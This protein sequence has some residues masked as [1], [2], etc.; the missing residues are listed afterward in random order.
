MRAVSWLF[1]IC[2][3]L[4]TIGVF[5][6]HLEVDIKSKHNSLSLYRAQADRKLA[7]RLL[8]GYGKSKSKK[9][10]GALLGFLMPRSKGT[11]HEVIDDT[12]SAMSELDDVSVDDAKSAG[13]MLAA[14]VWTYFGLQMAGFLLVLVGVVNDSYRR[15]RLI[16][17]AVTSL[18]TAAIAIACH[19]GAREIAAEANDEIGVHVFD[20][21][22]GSYLMVG[23]GIAAF[24]L[25]L[26]LVGIHVRGTGWKRYPLKASA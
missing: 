4:G 18:V 26:A 13:L 8:A 23:A 17:A 6:S 21:G 2:T 7:A 22:L 9:V 14:V 24:L 5:A 16:V 25:A 3:L 15:W 20:V 19:L 10:G 1:V 12:L 11:A